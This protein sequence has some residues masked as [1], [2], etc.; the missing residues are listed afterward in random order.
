MLELV[1]RDVA[2]VFVTAYDQ[3]AL[4]AFDVHAVDYLVKPF[5]K[6][7]SGRLCSACANGSAGVRSCQVEEIAEAARPRQGFSGRVLVRDGPRVHVLPV[8]KIDY[9][10][11][12]DDYVSFR[13]EGKDSLKDRPSLKSK[14]RWTRRNSSAL[15]DRQARRCYCFPCLL[16]FRDRSRWT[17][18]QEDLELPCPTQIREVANSNQ[19]RIERHGVWNRWH[20]K[21]IA[22]IG[23]LAQF[24]LPCSRVGIHDNVLGFAGILGRLALGYNAERQ[25]ALIRPQRRRPVVISIDENSSSALAEVRGEVYGSRALP[26]PAFVARYGNNHER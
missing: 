1:G 15:K 13:C 10:Q 8:E 14:P 3:Y 17:N 22:A 19:S 7:V 12:Q 24:V 26:H 5:A 9:V 23:N 11:A 20:D 16:C 4:R 21:K 25:F 6:S 2:V 18:G